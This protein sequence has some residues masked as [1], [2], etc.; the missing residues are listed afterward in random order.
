[1]P[2]HLL[3]KKSWNVYAPENIARVKRD[4]AS[5][6]AR[7]E[8][9]DRKQQED[10]SR[11]RLAWLR[12]ETPLITQNE[13]LSLIRK[14]DSKKD[15][16]HGND[17]GKRRRLQGEDDTDRDLR[18]AR[19]TM[20]YGHNHAIEHAQHAEKRRRSGVTIIDHEGHINLFPTEDKT[21]LGSH[22]N[23]GVEAEEMRQQRNN[24]GQYLR[25][26]NADERD[27]SSQRPWYTLIE[28]SQQ[29]D[30][31]FIE[32]RGIW[33]RPDSSAKLREQLRQSSND[34]LALMQKAQSQLKLAE[35]EKDRWRRE[36][37]ITVS[38]HENQ[39][40]RRHRECKIDQ[41]YRDRRISGTPERRRRKEGHEHETN[42]PKASSHRHKT[43]DQRCFSPKVRDDFRLDG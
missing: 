5:A 27:G 31:D 28:R 8:E 26:S 33:G 18:L 21:A 32:R 16:G 25:D 30:T 35:R 22:S 39:R 43:S 2:L 10:D 7:E 29:E 34:P 12:G 11:K 23:A 24:E 20:K 15:H 9:N 17:H 19:E 4:Q 42:Q 14:Q 13:H 41:L 37:Q 38:R 40:K 1:M 6:R 3:S 36:E